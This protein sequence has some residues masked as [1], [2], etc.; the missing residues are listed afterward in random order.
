MK[1]FLQH[2]PHIGMRKLK[3]ILG[4]FVGFWIWQGIRVF[5]PDLEVHPIY[6]YFYSVIEIRDSSEKT[7]SMSRLRLKATA[8]AIVIGL[9]FL[10]LTDVIRPFLTQSWM[11]TAVELGMILLGA[12]V[13][14]VVAECLGCKTFCGLAAVICILMLVSHGNDQRDQHERLCRA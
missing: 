4:L 14:L 2:L 5:F 6:I 8:V 10:A 11:H 9:V 1:H 7:V 12:L 13:T 3:S